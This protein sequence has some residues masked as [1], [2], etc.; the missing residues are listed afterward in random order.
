MRKT[1]PSGRTLQCPRSRDAK[2][3]IRFGQLNANRV[4]NFT[5]IFFKRYG[6]VFPQ[7]NN[8]FNHSIN[9]PG[10]GIPTF[11]RTFVESSFKAG[12]H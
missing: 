5:E 1:P 12:F 3:E 4:T 2:A 10:M 11:G 9:I 7:R 8:V 6:A